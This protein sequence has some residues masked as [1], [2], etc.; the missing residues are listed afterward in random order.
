MVAVFVVGAFLAMLWCLVRSQIVYHSIKD[1]FPPQFQD[2]LMSRYA[3]SVYALEPSTPLSLQAEYVKSSVAA[4]VACLCASL[5]FFSVQQ[6]VIGCLLLVVFFV[7]FFSTIKSWKTYKE[8]C[9]R[10]SGP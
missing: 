7:S 2:P 5:A 8:N 6:V 3:F 1:S 4:C 9:N 10:T